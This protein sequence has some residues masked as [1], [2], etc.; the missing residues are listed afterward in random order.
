MK[1]CSQPRRRIGIPLSVFI[2]LGGMSVRD[3]HAT[4]STGNLANTQGGPV[5]ANAKVYLIFW[6]TAFSTSGTPEYSE[7]N[8]TIGGWS[9]VGGSSSYYSVMRQYSNIGPGQFWGY[10]IENLAAC[11]QP[12]SSYVSSNMAGPGN[13]PTIQNFLTC[14][15]NNDASVPKPSDPNIV[16]VVLLPT[17]TIAFQ[18]D[19]FP[20]CP[21]GDCYGSCYSGIGNALLCGYHSYGTYSSSK[22]H[23]SVIPAM[24]NACACDGSRTY[25]AK[26][27]E[28]ETSTHE[29]AE[30]ITDPEN[31]AWKQN[32]YGCEI[33]DLCDTDTDY[34]INGYPVEKLWSNADGLCRS[35]QRWPLPGGGG[36][37]PGTIRSIATG[38]SADGRVY[39]FAIANDYS[40]WHTEETTAGNHTSWTNW[41]NHGVYAQQVALGRE[42]AAWSGSACTQEGRLVAFFI[43]T[44][45]KPNYGYLHEIHQITAPNGTAW[46]S[47]DKFNPYSQA[48]EIAVSRWTSGWSPGN[49]ILCWIGPD[50]STSCETEQGINTISFPPSAGQNIGGSS[51]ALALAIGGN[52][53]L[54][55]F[56]AG[57]CGTGT[58][59]YVYVNSDT[60]LGGWSG[61]SQIGTQQ[62]ATSGGTNSANG[63]RQGLAAT[64]YPSSGNIYLYAQ[65][66]GGYLS[67]TYETSGE[68]GWNSWVAITAP[69]AGYSG[70]I[71]LVAG[72]DDDS[73]SSPMFV[74]G[75][76]DR[77]IY[78]DTNYNGQPSSWSGWLDHAGRVPTTWILGKGSDNRN[79]IFTIG[80]YN[81]EGYY[82][83]VLTHDDYLIQMIVENANGGGWPNY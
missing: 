40:L 63:F 66:P 60:P 56:T 77:A 13:D 37:P 6:G 10:K 61:W 4:C 9:A 8:Y 39:L 76:A 47:D 33:A 79:I 51:Q 38:T 19:Q 14:V 55:V 35:V 50:R 64:V 20:N 72:N 58:W 7:F 11:G 49:Q 31:N 78:T 21:S 46:S 43:G 69:A 82:N 15:F 30:T 48:Y 28:F 80:G 45:T 53:Y 25:D 59:G 57:C 68:A 17:A 34:E 1:H 26:T 23:Y 75:A 29:V 44:E 3:A 36:L 52:G 67:Y 5:V 73:A 71:D 22:F 54:K 32:G 27:K 42:C 18:S 12:P 41:T 2:F 16:Y 24:T 74:L 83:S 62:A 70:W 81:N 65:K